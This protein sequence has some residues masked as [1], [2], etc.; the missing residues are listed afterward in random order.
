MP[1]LCKHSFFMSHPNYNPTLFLIVAYTD[2]HNYGKQ[3]QDSFP[4]KV[5]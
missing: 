2:L 1:L 5:L 4:H 3:Y